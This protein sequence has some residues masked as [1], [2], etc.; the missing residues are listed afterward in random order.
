MRISILVALAAVFAC[1]DALGPRG[2]RVVPLSPIAEAPPGADSVEVTFAIVNVSRDSIF[3]SRCGDSIVV[4]IDRANGDGSWFQSSGESCLPIFSTV[5][6]PLGPGER[7]ETARV[8]G[9]NGTYRIRVCVKRTLGASPRCDAASPPF[10]VR[11]T[12]DAPRVARASITVVTG[13]TIAG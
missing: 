11:G 6:L 9:E 2:V 7:A 4:G 13:G 8:F 12:R 10:R 3:L 5:P 1:T